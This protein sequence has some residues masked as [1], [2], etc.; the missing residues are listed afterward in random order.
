MLLVARWVEA[1]LTT[2]S[3]E[4]LYQIHG[5]QRE[6]IETKKPTQ[7]YCRFK[8]TSNRCLITQCNSINNE[9]SLRINKSNQFWPYMVSLFY[10]ACLSSWPFSKLRNI[11]WPEG[12]NFWTCSGWSVFVTSAILLVRISS[13]HQYTIDRSLE[14]DIFR[15]N[16]TFATLT[17]LICLSTFLI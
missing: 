5:S 14:F 12:L 16:T 10:T 9:T 13:K 15:N 11:L 4:T 8:V 1:W 6:N 17:Y 2:R 3:V 7:V